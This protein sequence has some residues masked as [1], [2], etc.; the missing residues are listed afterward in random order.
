M[1]SPFFQA[2]NEENLFNRIDNIANEM[3]IY[4]GLDTDLRLLMYLS[5]RV[6][7]RKA[8]R[9][10]AAANGQQTLPTNPNRR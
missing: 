8:K 1:H 4:L 10:Q 2:V 7:A 3:G 6:E 5:D 9:A